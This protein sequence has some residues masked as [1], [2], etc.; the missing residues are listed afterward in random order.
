MTTAPTNVARDPQFTGDQLATLRALLADA[1]AD[2]RAQ[3]EEHEALANSLTA[4]TD[5]DVGRGREAAHVAA[6]RAREGMAEVER[7]LSRMDEGTY[8]TCEACEQPIPF[9]RLEVIPQSRYCLTCS[10]RG[11]LVA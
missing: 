3:Y 2:H 4:D 8:G 10:D 11:G 1:L 5:D 9:E 7:A 6:T